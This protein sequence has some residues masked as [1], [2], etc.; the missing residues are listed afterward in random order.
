M[1]AEDVTSEI[2]GSSEPD[3]TP[4]PW[5]EGLGQ[6]RAAETFWLSTLLPTAGRT[7]RH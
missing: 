5:V 6:L 7:S 1:A 3:A 2:H 4:T